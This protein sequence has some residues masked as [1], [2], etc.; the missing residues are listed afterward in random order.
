MRTR[1]T[2]TARSE[3]DEIFRH[4]AK[5]NPVAAAAVAAAIRTAIARLAAFPRI[6][7]ATNDPNV[8]IKIARPYQYLIFYSVE[9]DAVIIRR[10]RH[11][12]R[13]RPPSELS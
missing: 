6:G 9:R 8:L 4:I 3:A 10:V 12:A 1:Y 7:A 13:P 5:D 2:A 11:P